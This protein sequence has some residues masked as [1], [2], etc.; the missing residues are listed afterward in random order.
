MDLTQRDMRQIVFQGSG[1]PE[2][3]AVERAP[4]P[5]PG[6]GQVLIEV[7]AAGIN[8][9]DCLQ[10]AGGYPPPPGATAIP[11]LEVAGHVVAVGADVEWP[12]VGDAA[13]ALVASGGYAEYCVADAALCLPVPAGMGMVEAACLPETFFTVYDNVFTRGRLKVGEILLTHGG[14]SGIGSTA[15]QLARAFGARVIAT[16]G[17][18]EKCAFCEELGAE[19][20]IDY[21]RTDF[22]AEVARLTEGRGV[23]VIL[24]MVGGDYIQ[25]N[26]ACL[27]LEGRLVQIAFLKGGRSEFDFRPMMMKRLTLC[28]STLRPRSVAQKAEIADALQERVWPLLDSG[29]VKP[30]IHATFA[31]EDAEAAHALM[32]S[33]AHMGKIA[34][35]M[36]QG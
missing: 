31:L 29:A 9:P 5:A 2:V 22:V 16:A 21:R 19:A 26:V 3:I 17:S 35:V 28:G 36:K 1:G 8:R 6:P 32:E 33:S 10:R 7:A 30:R 18:P 14:S 11:G 12:R 13:C 25:K 4:V 27:A 23:D 24:D 34:L 20:A 15:I